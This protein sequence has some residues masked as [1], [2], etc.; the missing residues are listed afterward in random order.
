VTLLDLLDRYPLDVQQ[1]GIKGGIMWDPEV[2]IITAPRI[3]EEE[4]HF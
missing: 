4:F 1:K 2:I 3:P